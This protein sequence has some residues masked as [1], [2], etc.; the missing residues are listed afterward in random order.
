MMSHNLSKTPCTLCHRFLFLIHG[1][2]P[3]QKNLHFLSLG[4]E[5]ALDGRKSPQFLPPIGSPIDKGA[6]LPG[7]SLLRSR[8]KLLLS[9]KIPRMLAVPK[10][11][12]LFLLLQPRRNFSD[13]LEVRS[14]NLPAQEKKAAAPRKV[15]HDWHA[16]Y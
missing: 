10:R 14:S 13:F 4:Q 2:H 12:K 9:E 8:G 15:P 1:L 6:C 3:P 11:P 5:L 16:Y 7:H